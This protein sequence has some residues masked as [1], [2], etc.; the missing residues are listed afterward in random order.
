MTDKKKLLRPLC[1]PKHPPEY[2]DF[3]LGEYPLTAG[4]KSGW[5]QWFGN[6]NPGEALISFEQQFCQ[7][8]NNLC[9]LPDEEPPGYLVLSITQGSGDPA[10][11]RIMRPGT[12]E[13]H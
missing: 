3:K 4:E 8:V 6:Y 9:P 7:N 5:F 11:G 10:M 12:V 13:Y 1:W 2:Q